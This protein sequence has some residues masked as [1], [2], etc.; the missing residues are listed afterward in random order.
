LNAL[1]T[2]CLCAACGQRCSRCLRRL[3]D[4]QRFRH[5]KLECSYRSRH[6]RLTR[7]R[8]NPSLC[9]RFSGTR[10]ELFS[11]ICSLRIP[12]P[13]LRSPLLLFLEISSARRRGNSWRGW[14]GRATACWHVLESHLTGH[15]P[16]PLHYIHALD[17]HRLAF[18]SLQQNVHTDANMIA[19]LLGPPCTVH[20]SHANPISIYPIS[21]PSATNITAVTCY[22]PLLILGLCTPRSPAGS[23][24]S[25]VRGRLLLGSSV[26]DKNR[27]LCVV[28]KGQRRDAVTRLLF[29]LRLLTRGLHL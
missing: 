13:G 23:D 14:R 28:G 5:K 7:S 29:A 15:F 26:K 12:N 16:L 11:H 20:V 25:L 8:A 3:L 17:L 19:T 4:W 22:Q 21:S 24:W 1:T 9:L 6:C 10:I 27:G 2:G 18:Y